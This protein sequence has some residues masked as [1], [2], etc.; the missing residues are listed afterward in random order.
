[1]GI[2]L[3]GDPSILGKRHSSGLTNVGQ[4]RRDGYVRKDLGRPD[5]QI[6]D[7]G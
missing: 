7:L 3:Q 2:R 5:F 6:I 4:T 1:M